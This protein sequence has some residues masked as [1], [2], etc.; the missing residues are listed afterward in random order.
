VHDLKAF[1]GTRAQQISDKQRESPCSSF[2]PGRK[3][4]S[5]AQFRNRG[6]TVPNQATARALELDVVGRLAKFFPEATPVRIPIKLSRAKSDGKSDGRHNGDLT[7][8]TNPAASVYFQ[9]TVIE[10]GTPREVL[11]MVDRPLEFADRVLVESND[12]TLHA[13]AS[14]VAV[15]YHPERTAV[16]ARFLTNVPNWIVK[17]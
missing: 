1:G 13:E 17:S 14:V 4:D 8:R 15:Q 2:K 9:D 3:G 6:T 11:F 7:S 10:F 12:G 5:A 16:A